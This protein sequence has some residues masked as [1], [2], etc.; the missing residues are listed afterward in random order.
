MA[1]QP[2]NELMQR[3]RSLIASAS[4]LV[5]A[6]TDLLE[7]GSRHL[8]AALENLAVL[9]QHPPSYIP[10]RATLHGARPTS[11]AASARTILHTHF[12]DLLQVMQQALGSFAIPGVQ[13]G[14][15]GSD[16]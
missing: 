7:H 4:D 3:M 10:V 1:A 12:T 9:L 6:R 8:T 13:P 15:G 16:Q 14:Q 2:V 5:A 11:E